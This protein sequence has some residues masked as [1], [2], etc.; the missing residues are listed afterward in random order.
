MRVFRA[1]HPGLRKGLVGDVTDL[2]FDDDSFDVAHCHAVLMHV[3]DTPAVLAEVKRVLKPGGII[4]SREAII[5]SSFSTPATR[6]PT[7]L[8]PP[9]PGSWP[10]TADTRRWA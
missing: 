10:A 6:R 4:A 7:G 3:P 5:S 2:P 9:S 1:T 8:G